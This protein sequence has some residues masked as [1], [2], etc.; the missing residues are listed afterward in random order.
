MTAYTKE[1]MRILRKTMLK[2]M[3]EVAKR[4]GVIVNF[5]NIRFGSYDFRVKMEARQEGVAAAA[6]ATPTTG[7]RDLVVGSWIAH[8]ARKGLMKV[9]SIEGKHCR[10]Q[11][12]RGTIYRIKVEEAARYA[13]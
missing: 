8:P 12:T 2:E 6:A 11:T 10:I 1:E 13:I 7:Q 3:E 5:G 4:Y 9:V